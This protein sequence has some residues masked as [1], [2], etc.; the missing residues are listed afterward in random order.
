M[1][2]FVFYDKRKKLIAQKV[3]GIWNPELYHGWGKEK[4]FFEGWYYKIVSKDEKNAFAFIPG[5]AMGESGEKQAFIQI[6]DGKK[7]T[8]EYIKFPFDSFKANQKEIE[9]QIAKLDRAIAKIDLDTLT[10]IS[11]QDITTKIKAA[12]D[13]RVAYMRA[14]SKENKDALAQKIREL[15][16]LKKTIA[17]KTK[18]KTQRKI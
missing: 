2:I 9:I 17:E 18:E 8:S 4:R 13:A 15:T 10:A 3:R 11:S 5:V 6:L 16:E 1:N 14:Q 12:E 7:S